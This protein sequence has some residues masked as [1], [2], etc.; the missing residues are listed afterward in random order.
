[1]KG[2]I[3]I[4]GFMITAEEWHGLDSLARTQLAEVITQ[5]GRR[6]SG[7]GPRPESEPELTSPFSEARSP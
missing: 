7:V 6:A 3:E 5:D 2:D 1:M 4:A